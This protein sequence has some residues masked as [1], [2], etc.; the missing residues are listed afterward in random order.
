MATT[1]DTDAMRRAVALAARALGATSPNP[2]VG[3]VILDAAG[4]P[5]GEGFH[6][7]GGGPP[8]GMPPRRAPR[9]RARGRCRIK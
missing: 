2:V 1:A 6:R 4:Q 3:C 7:R 8:A 5:A 9:A